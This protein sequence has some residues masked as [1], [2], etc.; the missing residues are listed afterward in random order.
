MTVSSLKLLALNCVGESLHLLN[1]LREK[2]SLYIPSYLASEIFQFAINGQKPFV[3]KQLVFFE[4]VCFFQLDH[5]S[6]KKRKFNGIED[7]R[8]LNNCSIESLS[9][10][11]FHSMFNLPIPLS[12]K[13]LKFERCLFGK[14][15]CKR[16][17]TLLSNCHSI[18]SFAMTSNDNMDYS[19]QYICNGLKSS[20]NSLLEINFSNCCLTRQHGYFLGNLFK[21]CTKLRAVNI[22]ANRELRDGFAEIFNGLRQSSESLRTLDFSFCNLVEEQ[23]SSFGDFLRKCDSLTE[24]NLFGNINLGRGFR[25]I[26]N[27]LQS[28]S[29]RTLSAINCD[30][31]LHTELQC[32]WLCDLLAECHSLQD[33]KFNNNEMSPYMIGQVLSRLTAFGNSL[34]KIDLSSMN[35]WENESCLALGNFFEQCTALRSVDLSSNGEWGKSFRKIC[36]G[37]KSS[38]HCLQRINLSNCDFSEQQCIWLGEFLNECSSLEDFFMAEN[39]NCGEGI[40]NISQGLRSS[41]HRLLTVDFSDCSLSAEQCVWL[42]ELLK[43]CDSLQTV[44]LDRNPVW[45]LGFEKICFGLKSSCRSLLNIS[46][47]KCELSRDQSVWLGNLL[48][49]CIMLQRIHLSSNE[50]FDMGFQRICMG[51]ISS[52]HSLTSVDFEGCNLSGEQSCWLG[53][54]LFEC[55]SLSEINLSENDNLGKGFEMICN[56]LKNSRYSLSIVS[57]KGCRLSGEKDYWLGNLFNECQSLQRVN[58]SMNGNFGEGF[59]LV[60]QGLRR[61]CLS[62]STISFEGCGLTIENLRHLSD[63]LAACTCLEQVNLIGVNINLELEAILNGLMSSSKCLKMLKYTRCSLSENQRLEMFNHLK[64]MEKIHA[65]CLYY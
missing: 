14:E 26:C 17:G 1:G 41:A 49:E 39:R 21:V 20:A 38:A 52:A 64:N 22:R 12:I 58:L 6:L 4:N 27:G 47:Y 37:L 65:S 10:I 36:E 62:L 16:L 54:F 15:E 30:Q 3:E 31:C 42:S 2:N 32:S 29:S 40:R 44:F 8:F 9:L 48:V 45:K 51:L 19:F 59:R 18:Q 25:M 34:L 33:C 57:L 5:I 56:G 43:R 11:N 63:L 61:S 13:S 24:I 7:F 50:Q 55:N 35:L 53:N 46:L 60:C 28:S 23:C